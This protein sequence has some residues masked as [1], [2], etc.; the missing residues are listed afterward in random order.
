M[1]KSSTNSIFL[2]AVYVVNYM[3][4]LL[5]TTYFSLLALRVWMFMPFARHNASKSY[6]KGKL[7]GNYNWDTYDS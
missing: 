1:I 2:L 6:Y 4:I 7:Q 5:I 3:F